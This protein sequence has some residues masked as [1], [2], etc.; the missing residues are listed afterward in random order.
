MMRLDYKWQ[1]AIVVALGLFLSLLD[2][3]I[4]SVAFLAIERKVDHPVMDLRLL[5]NPTFARA[6][7][8]LWALV[9][10]PAACMIVALVVGTDP[11]L[12]SPRASV[13]VEVATI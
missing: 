12:R 4:V 1:A 9:A 6:S 5:L 2:N 3:M 7:L 11:S 10:F 13:H 8:L